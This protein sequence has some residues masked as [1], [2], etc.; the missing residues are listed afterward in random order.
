MQLVNLSDFILII[1]TEKKHQLILSLEHIVAGLYLTF[2]YCFPIILVGILV[3]NFKEL[4][5]HRDNDETKHAKYCISCYKHL[6]SS[7]ANFYFLYFGV[8]QI[9]FITWTF[10]GFTKLLEDKDHKLYEYIV[11]IACIL[12]L[13]KS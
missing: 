4:C 6:T 8:L 1:D 5:K 11:F 2:F 10:N 7:L 3:E 9:L 12:G 13:S